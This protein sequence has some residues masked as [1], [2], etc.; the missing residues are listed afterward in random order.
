MLCCSWFEQG[1]RGGEAPGRR[2]VGVDDDAGEA[3]E[4]RL[5]RPALDRH[6]AEAL[7][8]EVRLVH[9]VAAALQRVL[10]LLLRRPEVGGVEVAVLVEHLGVA[11]GHR[12]PRRAPH[13]Q[14]HVAHHVLAH[15]D[16]RLAGGRLQDLHRADLLDP[17]DGRARG[18]DERPLARPHH[19]HGRP[20]GVRVARGAPAG[21]LEPR[22]VGLSV[23][24]VRRPDRP[25]GRLPGLARPHGLRPPVRVLDPQLAQQREAV[26]VDGPLVLPGEEAAVPAVAEHRADRVLARAQVARDVVR[27][28]LEA[29]VVARPAGGE[30][31]VAHALPVDL[32]L[33]EAEAGD[34]GAG[35]AHLPL[36]REGPAQHRRRLGRLRA[37][38]LGRLDP[39]GL[40]VPGRQQ[41]HLPVPG[42]APG[43]GLPAAV[44]HP[45]PPGVAARGRERGAAVRDEDGAVR[46]D[47]PG[48]PD[49]PAVARHLQLVG[50]LHDAP[51]VGAQLPAQPRLRHVDPQGVDLVLAAQVRHRGR[52]ARR[53]GGEGGRGQGGE[54]GEDGGGQGRDLAHGGLLTPRSRPEGAVAGSWTP[55]I[56]PPRAGRGD[57]ADGS[58][59]DHRSEPLELASRVV[60]RGEHRTGRREACGTRGGGR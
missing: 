14:A 59:G 11:Q 33:V 9:L 47:L 44:P 22:V 5:A 17:P 54:G 58:C 12:R 60:D 50:G 55:G 1:V 46:G 38:V 29:V 10:H 41:P 40:P 56:M 43:R 8:G 23:V 51:S 7:E 31:L 21:A 32:Q 36:H 20:V 26:P 37:L 42:R 57:G 13:L 19:D 34:V 16:D 53:R 25:R 39:A 2:H 27:L 30:E 35:G 6:V 3:V 4:G 48:V 52:R 45:H 18:G 28:V 24:D 15:V 49:L